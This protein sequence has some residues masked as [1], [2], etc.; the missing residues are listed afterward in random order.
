MPGLAYLLDI[1]STSYKTVYKLPTA[2]IDLI[3]LCQ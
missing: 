2:T 3:E 1:Y